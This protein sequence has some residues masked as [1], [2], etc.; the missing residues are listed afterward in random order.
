VYFRKRLSPVFARPISPLRVFPAG[1]P[2]T[3]FRKSEDYSQF[4]RHVAD[5]AGDGASI[6]CTKVIRGITPDELIGR[7][8]YFGK[9]V[10]QDLVTDEPNDIA[11]LFA[12][13]DRRC[14]GLNGSICVLTN[15]VSEHSGDPLHQFV[16]GRICFGELNSN[17][18]GPLGY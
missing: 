14:S 18:E 4:L 7:L 1:R 12:L 6:A 13:V 15:L 17:T 16:C 9:R 2:T 10:P 8:S 11:H 3:T 5:T